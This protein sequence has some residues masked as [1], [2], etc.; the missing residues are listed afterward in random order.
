VSLNDNIND[1]TIDHELNQSTILHDKT[2]NDLMLT[3]KEKLKPT[4]RELNQVD[5]QLDSR[6]E[7]NI[8]QTFEN[9]HTL[10]CY[11]NGVS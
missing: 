5:N 3:A 8:G 10:I 11:D 6:L 1:N 9:R 7:S 4:Q 2:H